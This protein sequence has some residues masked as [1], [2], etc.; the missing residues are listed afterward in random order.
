MMPHAPMRLAAAR[1][2]KG[3]RERPPLFPSVREAAE[4]LKSD[5]TER[6]ERKSK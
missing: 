6:F 1:V 4:T 3:A 2:L 5:R